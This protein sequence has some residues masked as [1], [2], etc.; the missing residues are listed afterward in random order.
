MYE[1]VK[2][3][4]SCFCENCFWFKMEN[5]EIVESYIDEWRIYADEQFKREVSEV[6]EI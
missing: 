6:K 3:K 2:H 5:P 1:E 4:P